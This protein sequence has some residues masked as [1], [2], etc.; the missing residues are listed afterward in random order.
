MDCSEILLLMVGHIVGHLS[1]ILASNGAG[2]SVHFL[3]R[4][5]GIFR[6]KPSFSAFL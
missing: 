4:N 2:R 5:D 1:V 3:L 6:M